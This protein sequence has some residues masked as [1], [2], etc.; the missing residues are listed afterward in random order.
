MVYIYFS[1]FLDT[2]Y[3]FIVLILSLF[4]KWLSGMIIE[5]GKIRENVYKEDERVFSTKGKSEKYKCS[6]HSP[7]LVY[8]PFVP[9]Y[10]T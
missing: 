5:W 1:F 3:I 2:M 4:I 10:K 6:N 7:T 9:K 8:T